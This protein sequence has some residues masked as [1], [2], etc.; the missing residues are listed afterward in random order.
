M[1]YLYSI[2]SQ[3]VSLHGGGTLDS[4]MYVIWMDFQGKV[5]LYD[6]WLDSLAAIKECKSLNSRDDSGAHY[7]VTFRGVLL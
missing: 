2:S 4:E 5:Y 6:T 3:V 7:Y 1:T